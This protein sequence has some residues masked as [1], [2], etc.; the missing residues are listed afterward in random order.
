MNAEMETKMKRVFENVGIRFPEDTQLDLE[1]WGMDSVILLNLIV[2]IEEEYEIKV[3]DEKL[4]YENFSTLSTI[5]ES[6]NKIL[7]KEE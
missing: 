4:L 2:N 1:E 6:V 7:Q 5:Y 3:P